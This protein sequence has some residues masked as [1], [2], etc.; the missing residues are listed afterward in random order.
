MK[1]I[2]LK[3]Y[4]KKELPP[5]DALIMTIGN[6]ESEGELSKSMREKYSIE[7]S[8]SYGRFSIAAL[9]RKR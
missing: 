5:E 6:L 4:S 1:D 7:D 8:A 9:E 3:A 2:D